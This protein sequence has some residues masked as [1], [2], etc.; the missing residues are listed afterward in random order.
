MRAG[1]QIEILDLITPYWTLWYL[2]SLVF[3]KTI[4]YYLTP[5]L[6]NNTNLILA[7]CVIL[8]IVCGYISNGRL[9]GIQRTISFYPF[10]LYGY[11]M[12]KGKLDNFVKNKKTAYIILLMALCLAFLLS[13]YNI[14][15]SIEK[16]ADPYHG[17][18]LMVKAMLIPCSLL[19]SLSIW[20]I[21]GYCHIFSFIGKKSLSI[22][23]YHTIFISFVFLPIAHH[24]ELPKVTI[25]L[26]LYCISLIFIL[27]IWSKTKL[28][29]YLLNP[30]SVLIKKADV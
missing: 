23:V 12:R 2:L 24:F 9:L 5:V 7:V 16:G 1:G 21:F 19:I 25:A 11:Y 20:Y 29:Q 6:S 15:L 26:V 13:K 30:I 22:Y 27:T 14:I 4:T 17:I 8:S 3:W 10:F 28:S 18:L